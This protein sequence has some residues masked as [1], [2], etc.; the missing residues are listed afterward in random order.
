MKDNNMDLD[1]FISESIQGIL[2]GIDMAGEKVKNKRIGLYSEG[3]AN[4]RHIE[5]DI[6]VS[7]SGKSERSGGGGGK[8]K[9]WGILDIGADAKKV[10]ENTN[11]TVSRIKF[12]VRIK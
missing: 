1:E 6:A 8:I 7:A 3:G 5:F 2:R 9:A 11:S 12:G 10:L 4:R